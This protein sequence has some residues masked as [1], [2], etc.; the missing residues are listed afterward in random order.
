MDFQIFQIGK[1]FPCGFIALNKAYFRFWINFGRP[2]LI[3][4][5]QCDPLSRRHAAALDVVFCQCV[6]SFGPCP[7]ISDKLIIWVYT[8]RF[9]NFFPDR[10]PRR[11]RITPTAL[12]FIYG[13]VSVGISDYFL[14]SFLLFFGFF[15]FNLVS[16]AFFWFSLYLYLYCR[17]YLY[18]FFYC[19]LTP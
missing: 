19:I 18:F 14:F 7:I 4:L 16:F 12:Q 11:P 5:P 13:A 1:T 17:L 9:R 15:W 3:Y 10:Y 2:F 8:A 6:Q